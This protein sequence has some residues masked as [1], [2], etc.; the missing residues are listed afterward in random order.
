MRRSRVAFKTH[1]G[2]ELFNDCLHYR[3]VAK[4]LIA[5]DREGNVFEIR[6]ALRSSFV[7]LAMYWE[8]RVNDLVYSE[9]I[10]R[11]Y[12]QKPQLSDSEI[13]RFERFWKSD[14]GL[15]FSVLELL[16]GADLRMGSKLK[17]RIKAMQETRNLILHTGNYD[18]RYSNEEFL[19]VLAD[20]IETTR[21][22]FAFLEA[23]GLM[24]AD[25]FLTNEESVDLIK[26]GLGFIKFGQEKHLQSVNRETNQDG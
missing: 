25:R 21:Q 23:K 20:G 8:S 13:R 11:L 17:K 15:K 6:R 10:H 26:H 22:F 16:T 4:D 1:L 2:F 9:I 12:D 24:K 5:R 3:R 18:W 19:R 7:C 14:V